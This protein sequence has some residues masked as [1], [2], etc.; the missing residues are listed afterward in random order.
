[1]IEQRLFFFNTEKPL[2]RLSLALDIESMLVE[3]TDEDDFL[4][5]WGGALRWLK[6]DVP[7]EIIQST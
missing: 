1:M 4:Y 3:N 5:E 6:S 7:A 2:R